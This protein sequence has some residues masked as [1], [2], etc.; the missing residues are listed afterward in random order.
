MLAARPAN[1]ADD[2]AATEA[3]EILASADELPPPAR[4]VWTFRSALGDA[5]RERWSEQFAGRDL[6]DPDRAA[7]AFR[8]L[9][10]ADPDD[11][12]AAFNLGLC[13]AWDGRNA[14]AVAALDRS[15]SLDAPE[16]FDHAAAAWTLAEVLRHGAGA[17]AIAD[18]VISALH[19]HWPDDQGDP[20]A[21]L[22][23]F[24]PIRPV[25]V[26]LDPAT[27]EPVS[28]A[29]RLAEWLDAPDD[30][31][32]PR[33]L[34]EVAAG[35]GSLRLSSPDRPSL[36]VAEAM[37]SA[38]LGD[39]IRIAGRSAT[40]L[41]LRFLDAAAWLV[42]VPSGDDDPSALRAAIEDYYENLWVTR[43]RIG[44]AGPDGRPRSPAQAAS[45]GDDVT[46][47]KLSAVVTVREGLANRPRMVAM[48]AGYPFD[49]LRRRLGLPLDVES[50]VE[51]NDVTCMSASELDRLDPATLSSEVLLDALRAARP[52]CGEA[53]V[54]KF[55]DTL[56]RLREPTP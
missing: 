50:S 28:T 39:Q 8:A 15:V 25:P 10:E 55:A 47:A 6:G 51:P 14:E 7:E 11:S 53:T 36:E 16:R 37:V 48:A 35:A 2:P 45:A 22:A 4:K 30:S 54:A 3:L 23:A 52:V 17:E 34:V 27:G 41:P 43:P 46:R 40:P 13:L 33:V 21:A 5:R 32:P 12:A 31:R 9:V 38:E 42:R 20:I 19:L 56:T 26:P 29:I 1:P 44:L 18:D 49:R 24:A